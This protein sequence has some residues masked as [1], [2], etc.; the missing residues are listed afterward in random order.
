MNNF[1]STDGKLYATMNLVADVAVIN[2]LVLLCSLPIFTSG[3][4]VSAG[5]FVLISRLEERGGA[6][7]PSFWRE[8]RANLGVTWM[9]SLA[10]GFLLILAGGQ[11]W[12]ITQL[13]QGKG[14]SSGLALSLRSGVLGVSALVLMLG[15][16]IFW[17]VAQFK[18]NGRGHLRN[19]MVLLG[20]YL[21]ISV[22]NLLLIL[23]PGLWIIWRGQISAGLILI[24]LFFG[25]GFTMYLQDLLRLRVR[26]TLIEA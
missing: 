9:Y 4:A 21:P 14:I 2:M 26:R 24:Y 15:S 5:H 22:L 8:F 17:L 23:A 20:R 18:N 7:M 13:E 10:L 16:W 12:M 19:A 25:V 6:V 11:L 3:A 1:F